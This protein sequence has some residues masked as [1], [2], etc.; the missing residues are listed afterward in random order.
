[1]AYTLN[2]HKSRTLFVMPLV[3]ACILAGLGGCNPAQKDSAAKT[4]P[5]ILAED[6]GT[7]LSLLMGMD[8]ALGLGTTSQLEYWILSREELI[9]KNPYAERSAGKDLV[10]AIVGA[11]AED[12]AGSAAASLK[13]VELRL[14]PDPAESRLVLQ[15]S[16]L[17]E[18]SPAAMIAIF[19]EPL[20]S[21][22]G[23]DGNTHLIFS[24]SAGGKNPVLVELITSHWANGRCF[25]AAISIQQGQ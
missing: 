25:A 17:V 2:M 6:F 23:M 18:M 11:L 1:M 14:F 19:G 22:Q 7:G 3:L 8:Q 4:I 12:G 15:G 24:L 13:V 9:G 21:D 5:N 16:P 20:S 10:V